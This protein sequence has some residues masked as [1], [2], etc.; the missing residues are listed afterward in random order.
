M[1]WQ[2]TL[3]ELAVMAGAA[4]P[5]EDATFT[6]VSTDTRTLEPGQVFFALRGENFDGHAFAAQAFS[7]G[8]VAVVSHAPCE[9]GPTLAVPD[10]LD[11]LQRFAAAHR[12]RHSLPVFA[13]TGSCGKTTAKEMIAAVLQSKY[14]VVKTQGNLN[15]EIGCPLSLLQIDTAT[16]AA[17]IE[18]GANHAGEIARLCELAA[19]TESAIT[20][21]APAHLEGFGSE[22][23]VAAAKA[24]IM[25]GLAGRGCFYVNADDPRCVRIGERHPGETVWF[26]ASGDV[27]LRHCALGPD[28][29]MRLDIAPVGTLRLPLLVK[30]HAGNV[31][32]AVAVGLRHGIEEFE[33][34]LRAACA[35]GAR[36]RREVISGVEVLDDT[37]NANPASMAAALE[38]LGSRTGNRRIAALGEMLELGERAEEL[39]A[40][41]GACAAGNGVTHL[42]ARGPHAYA[43][44]AAAREAGVPHAEV[45]DEHDAIA[46]A[47]AAVA[48]PGDAVLAKGSR[49]MRM[50]QVLDCLRVRLESPA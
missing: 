18:M 16:E 21:I 42:F 20:M 24:E 25:E 13:L 4:P 19:P 31:L 49:G 41:V 8:A 32:L 5:A 28:G 3:K 39:H 29:E 43:M 15:N 33:A 11:A 12:R 46:E 40:R 47:I 35:A 9:A 45:I 17:V 48:H 26:G 7:K 2:Y 50:E 23:G 44:I 37:Y 14:A 38:T 36:F 22:E 6:G 34:P 30:A 1:V 27:V 10:P